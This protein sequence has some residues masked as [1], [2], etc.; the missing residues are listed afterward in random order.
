MPFPYT[1]VLITG[2]TAGIGLALAERMIEKGVFVIAVGRR[3]D[4]L[5]AL[6]AK[7]GAD[8]IAVDNFDVSDVEAIPAWAKGWVVLLLSH[9]VSTMNFKCLLN[10]PK[11]VIQP[12]IPYQAESVNISMVNHLP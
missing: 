7:H 12:I 8:K 6:L 4:R 9:V 3:K 2:A 5:D 1:N 11:P 10:E